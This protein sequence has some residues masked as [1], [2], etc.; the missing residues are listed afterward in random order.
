MTPEELE[1][2]KKRRVLDRL[3]ERLADAEEAMTDLRVEME[4]FEGRYTIEVARLYADLDEIE[5]EIAE[6]EY[7]LVPDDEEI[8]R[9]AEELRRKAE[10]SA[11][12]ALED[13]EKSLTK[14]DPTPEARKAY[15]DLARIIHPDLALDADEKERRHLLMADLNLA[16]SSG[17]QEKL[18]ML[19]DNYRHSPD[20]IAGDSVANELVR[21]IRQIYQVTGRLQTLRNERLEAEASESFELWQRV[22]SEMAEGRDMLSQ[23]A[24]RARVHILR[25]QR[26]LNDL[27]NLN[28]AQ[29]EYVKEKYG[30]DI[31]EFRKND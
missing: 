14:F 23:M 15:H 30:M 31:G 3:K 22:N 21:A 17:D 25:S 18:K 5:A 6:E 28:S 24:A 1:L 26:R 2:T 27:R 20:L 4:R 11:M 29:E 16:Y 19:A 9:K 7:K 8:K 10:D 13:G 12:R